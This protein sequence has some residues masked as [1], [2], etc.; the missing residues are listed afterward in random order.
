MITRRK[1]LPRS[2]GK[3]KDWEALPALKICATI[4]L[5]EKEIQKAGVIIRHAITKVVKARKVA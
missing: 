4:G 1:G 2:T 5:T 3:V